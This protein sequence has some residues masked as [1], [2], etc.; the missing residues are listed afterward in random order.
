MSEDAQ[1]EAIDKLTQAVILLGGT[2]IPLVNS[3]DT[4]KRLDPFQKKL[5]AVSKILFEWRRRPPGEKAPD[6]SNADHSELYDA[7]NDL[8]ER[9]DRHNEAAAE[10]EADRSRPVHV[11]VIR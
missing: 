5:Q 8:T 2:L 3:A 11:K 10:R 4:L 7:V 1:W 9:L 6:H